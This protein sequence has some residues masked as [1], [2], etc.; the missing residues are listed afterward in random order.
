MKKTI[1]AAML[2]AACAMNAQ[3]QKPYQY[4]SPIGTT[5]LQFDLKQMQDSAASTAAYEAELTSLQKQLKQEGKNLDAEMKSLK[6]EKDLY[7]KQMDMYKA[8]KSQTEKLMKNMQKEV[9]QY[10]SYLKNI[11]K[12]QDIIKK[13]DNNS[14][15]AIRQ[16]SEYMARLEKRCQKE[17]NRCQDIVDDMN[18][19]VGSELSEAYAL[20]NS[21]LIEITD[22]ETRLKN[23]VAQSKTNQDIVK[24]ALKSAKGK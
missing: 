4:V 9:E 7:A 11:S 2:L 16:Q 3:E 18:R 10:E 19:G 22:K 17:K 15:E 24:T 1:L 12:C 6:C 21:F 13:I 8:R 20:L 14:C 5:L 23:L